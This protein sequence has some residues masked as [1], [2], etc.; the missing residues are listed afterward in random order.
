MPVMIE[1]GP[2]LERQADA[3]AAARQYAPAAALLAKAA[4]LQPERSE[5]WTKLSAMRRASGDL[6]GALTAIERALARAPLDFS[7]LLGRAFILEQLGSEVAGEAFC[8]AVAQLPDKGQ[9]PAPM[10]AAVAHALM[11]S[12]E[13]K[14]R[15]SLRLQQT[16][17]ND[18]SPAEQA[19]AYRFISNIARETTHHHQQP[20]HFHYP[21][22]PE[23][24]FH[25]P[26]NF[27]G[28]TE[29]A[30]RSDIIREELEALLEAESA[31]LVPYIQYPERIALRQ[32]EDLNRNKRWSALHLLQNGTRVEKNARH[33][34]RTME[35]LAALDQPVVPGASPNA[36]FSLL[37]PHTQI[38]PHSGVANTRLVAHLPLIVPPHCGFRCGATTVAWE[39]GT[40]FVFDD[41]IEHEAWNNSDKLRVVLIFD[42]WVPQLSERERAAV[43]RIMPAAGTTS[44][45]I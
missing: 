6:D 16:L 39:V 32:W 37:A 41:T 9:V 44:V 24:E 2:A 17:G 29:L 45:G 15:T 20:T 8:E 28:L 1:D 25:A 14:N 7:N 13:H 21:G 35:A 11:R 18:L 40:P 4:A 26:E 23:V 38:P 31:E 33:C 30:A 12:A 36:M 42:L 10:Q 5:L 27:A 3:A 19:R 22:L 43:S 34:P